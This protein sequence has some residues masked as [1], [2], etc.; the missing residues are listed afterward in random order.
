MA[1]IYDSALGGDGTAEGFTTKRVLLSG[2]DFVVKDANGSRLGDQITIPKST[3]VRFKRET[4]AQ[5]VDAGV[6]IAP[7]LKPARDLADL[8]R[9]LSGKTVTREVTLTLRGDAVDQKK[10]T[11]VI[12]FSSEAEVERWFGIEV[13]S[14]DPGHVRMDRLNNGAPLLHGHNR[15]DQVGVVDSA[16]IAGGV[17]VAVIRLSR[18]ARGEE[19]LQDLADGIRRKVSVGYRIHKVEVEK[20][21]SDI[22]KVRVIDWEPQEVSIVS[23]PADDSVGVI[24][25][26]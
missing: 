9:E 1:T 25:G 14:H 18:S 6:V 11:A 21:S 26:S 7:G 15:N 8:A 4:M 19:F 5:L 3:I 20:V 12:S 24:I 13:L 17:G 2:A 16:R 22:E 10:R 23:I